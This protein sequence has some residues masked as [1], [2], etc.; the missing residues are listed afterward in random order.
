[1]D[2]KQYGELINLRARMNREKPLKNSV[3][4]T[5]EEM[6][7]LTKCL[8]KLL[9]VSPKFSVENLTEELA[10]SLLMINDIKIR[11]NIKDDDINK[12]QLD[13]LRRLYNVLG[14]QG[15]PIL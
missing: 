11:F 9:R 1:M 14:H 13:A 4:C 2:I 7:E 5:I 6:S 10:H 15:N 8:T 3:Y 12:Y